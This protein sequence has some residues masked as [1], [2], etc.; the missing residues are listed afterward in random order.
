[1]Q[2]LLIWVKYLQINKNEPP[3]HVQW[4]FSTPSYKRGK[5]LFLKGAIKGQIVVTMRYNLLLYIYQISL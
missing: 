5:Y 2:Q 4:L 1:M 3:H